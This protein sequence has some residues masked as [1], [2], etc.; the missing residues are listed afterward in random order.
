M[1]LQEIII[2]L[3]HIRTELPLVYRKRIFPLIDE[4][5][6]LSNFKSK[7]TNQ[8]GYYWGHLIPKIGE[9]IGEIDNELIHYALKNRFLKILE[10]DPLDKSKREHF[11]I[12]K[13]L[14]LLDKEETS[15]YIDKVYY[16]GIELGAD[17]HPPDPKWKGKK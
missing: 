2:R 14:S 3:E 10:C 7:T 15:T 17:V 8:L 13:D 9:C 11:E 16:F 6:K 1:N 4:L 12:A 5:I